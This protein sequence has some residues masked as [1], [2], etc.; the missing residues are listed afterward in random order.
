MTLLSW[1][2]VPNAMA[3]QPSKIPHVREE[4]VDLITEAKGN[5]HM[6]ARAKVPALA[7]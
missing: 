1:L 5:S 3:S 2:A 6:A 4:L 7:T